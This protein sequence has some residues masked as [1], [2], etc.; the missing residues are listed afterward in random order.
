MATMK[1]CV[2]SGALAFAVL[3]GLLSACAD[4]PVEIPESQFGEPVCMVAAS[5]GHWEDGRVHFILDESVNLAPAGCGC[6]PREDRYDWSEDDLDELAL[7][8]LAECER[9]AETMFDF[10]WNDCRADYEAKAWYQH[11][12]P[13]R[14][15]SGWSAYRPA[16]LD[17]IELE[18]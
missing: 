10:D 12:L 18:P 15:E 8:T 5:W 14:D 9:M 17:C 6:L 13:V 16:E 7:L 2:G 4:E 3:L 1:R 11:V